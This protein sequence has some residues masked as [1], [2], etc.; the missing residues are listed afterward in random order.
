MLRLLKAINIVLLSGVVFVGCADVKGR[1]DQPRLDQEREQ[2]VTFGTA[3]LCRSTDRNCLRQHF[4]RCLGQ[5]KKKHYFESGPPDRITMLATGEVVAE[6]V[7][8]ASNGRVIITYDQDGVA[9]QW[10]YH[11]VW[12]LLQSQRITAHPAG[13][14]GAARTLAFLFERRKGFG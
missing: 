10:Q 9:R 5:S 8:G 4:N 7:L 11:A 2:Y 12:G 14:T 3:V 6:W 13:I 1:F